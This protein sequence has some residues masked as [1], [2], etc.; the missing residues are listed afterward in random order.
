M[1]YVEAPIFIPPRTE[2]DSARTE[3]VESVSFMVFLVR[4]ILHR[5]TVETGCPDRV[6][7]NLSSEISKLVIGSPI[8]RALDP[9]AI[10][11]GAART[12]D[13][14]AFARR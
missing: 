2:S 5:Q 11:A 10:T 6:T 4:F 1:G 3:V 8:T 9:A 13:P 12:H 14:E 7:T